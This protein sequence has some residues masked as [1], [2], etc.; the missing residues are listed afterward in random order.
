[1]VGNM[2]ENWPML[3]HSLCLAIL[4]ASVLILSLTSLLTARDNYGDVIYYTIT[5]LTLHRS[6]SVKGPDEENDTI[7]VMDNKPRTVKGSNDDQGSNN[8]D[9][10]KLGEV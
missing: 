10:S 3:L 9:N 4:C 2:L 7:L 6:V 1:M 5:I 8:L